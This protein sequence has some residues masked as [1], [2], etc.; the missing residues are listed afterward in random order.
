MKAP[1]KTWLLRSFRHLILAQLALTSVL[2]LPPAIQLLM[3]SITPAVAMPVNIAPKMT[4]GTTTDQGETASDLFDEEQLL[5]L[6]RLPPSVKLNM[7]RAS[8]ESTL[9][10]TKIS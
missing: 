4:T 1:A 9:S 3:V 10:T 6:L 8:T 5:T 7:A 2:I